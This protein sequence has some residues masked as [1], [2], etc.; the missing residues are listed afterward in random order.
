MRN[1]LGSLFGDGLGSLFG[2]G[3]LWLLAVAA[4][5]IALIAGVIWVVVWVL[6]ALNVIPQ[7]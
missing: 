7:T 4:V 6:R 5:N 1:G 3:I 2:A